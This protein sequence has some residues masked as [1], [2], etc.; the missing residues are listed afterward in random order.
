MYYSVPYALDPPNPPAAKLTTGSLP[1]SAV[2]FNSSYE[3]PNCLA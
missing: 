1:N 2:F 3:T